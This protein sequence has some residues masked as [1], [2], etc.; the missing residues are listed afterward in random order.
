MQ[1]TLQAAYLSELGASHQAMLGGE[2][3]LAFGHLARAHIPGQ[4]FAR[5]HV[6]VHWLM[7]RLGLRAGDARESFGQLSRMSAFA[8]M[9][10][11]EDLRRILE[12][13]EGRRHA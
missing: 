12:Q 8:S 11:P 10:V 13:S 3:E 6:H 5:Q 2:T 7:F 9:P 4:R 1:G